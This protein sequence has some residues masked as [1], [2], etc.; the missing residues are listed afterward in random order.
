MRPKD[1]ARGAAIKTAL[2]AF[3]Q[4]SHR[5]PGI[6][7][8]GAPD[9]LVEQ[10]VESMRRIEYVKLIHR[11]PHCAVRGDPASEF[12]D[13]LMAASF[14]QRAGAIDEACWLVFLSVHFGKNRKAGWR[15]VRD[16][17]GALG[18]QNKW[19]WTHVSA[20]PRAFAQ[21]LRSNQAGL[22]PDGVVR[23]GNHRKYESIGPGSRGTAKVVDSY[24]RW[25]L[26]HGDHIGLVREARRS[27]G[28]NPGALFDHLYRSMDS[29]LSFG[30]MARFDYLTMLGKLDLAPIE[31]GIPYLNG[32]TGPLKGARLL[33]GGALSASLPFRTLDPLVAELGAHLGV[34]MQVME[35]ALCNWQK[36]PRVF[37]PFRG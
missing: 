37:A 26:P 22:K 19:D 23:F 16:V 27:V 32:A 6:Q 36:S 9:S 35:D 31:P 30:R 2:L 20:D 34:G 33:F 1:A 21:W 14:A 29:V 3:H 24:V 15:L 25:V 13:P 12:F 17:Y 7:P 10:I 5:L 8:A 11:K 28:N 18:G 4:R